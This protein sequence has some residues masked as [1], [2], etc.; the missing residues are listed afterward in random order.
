M[1]EF[2]SNYFLRIHDSSR[3]IYIALYHLQYYGSLGIIFLLSKFASH[4]VLPSAEICS[5]LNSCA[6]FQPGVTSKFTELES[7]LKLYQYVTR[8]H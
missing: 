8:N 1:T 5:R 2:S 3:R 4:R 7:D 6:M